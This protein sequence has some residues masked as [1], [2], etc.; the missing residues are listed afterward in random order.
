MISINNIFCIG[1][2]YAKHI[3]ELGHERPKEPTVFLKPSNTL[4]GNREK[5]ILP[6]QSQNV[7]YEG[8]LILR[9]GKTTRHVAETDALSY[10]SHYAIGIDVTARDIQKEAIESGNPW[11]ISKGFDSFSQLSEFVPAEKCQNPDNL[12][13]TLHVNGELKQ[14][15][16]T[17]NMIFP[18]AE[19]ISYL[20]NTFTLSEGDVIFTGTPEGVGA[21][22]L[23]DIVRVSL[24][25]DLA[26]LEVPVTN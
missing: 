26:S 14:A 6:K 20:S 12:N 1:R 3:E 11:V 21:L 7:H 23:G 16:H 19:I 17:K 2:N 4:I 5:I 8:E 18:V 9:I 13:F 22:S 15:G 25:G 24:E 10:I